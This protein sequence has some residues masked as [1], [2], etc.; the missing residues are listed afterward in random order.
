MLR[1]VIFAL[2]AASAALFVP[3]LAWAGIRWDWS[4]EEVACARKIGVNLGGAPK[5]KFFVRQMTWL[6][7]AVV[8]GTVTAVEHEPSTG[9]RTTVVLAV[10]SVHKGD[11][12]PPTI[13]ILL[14]DGPFYSEVYGQM[15]EVDSGEPDFER[16]ERVLVFLTGGTFRSHM[17]GMNEV[18]LAPHQFGVVDSGKWT[19]HQDGT[20]TFGIVCTSSVDAGSC[21]PQRVD[22]IGWMENEIERSRTAQAILC[23]R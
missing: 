2:G 13:E 14:N 10:E 5:D 6:S 11:Q 7:D 9:F 20:G 8:T 3:A 19:I 1:N 12:I 15:L 4:A 23:R 17:Q 22:G 21:G 18:S 16:G